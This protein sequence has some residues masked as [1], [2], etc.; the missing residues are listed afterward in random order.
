MGPKAKR[1]YA[2]DLRPR[3]KKATKSEKKYM[4]DEFSTTCQYN[5]KYAIRL[6]NALR[7]MPRG[8][9]HRGR[10]KQ[11]TGP[12]ILEVLRFI[13]VKTNLPCSK[14]LKA[15]LSLWLP[16]YP[17]EIP[18][19][20]FD[21]LLKISPATIDRLMKPERA[22]YQKKGLTFTK[23]G[24]LIKKHIP[25]KT[26][27]WDETRPGF[28]EVDSVAHCGTSGAGSF[29]FT[30]NCVDIATTWTEQRA[31]WGKGER[32]VLN[33]MKNIEQSLPFEL[34]GFDCDNGSE[35][36]NWHLVKHYLKRK[37]PI[38]F[39]RAR[40]YHKNDNAHIEEKNW[41]HIRQYL[42]YQRFDK[43][44]LVD[45][46]NDLYT[47]EWRLYF[48]FFMPSVKLVAKYREGSKIIKKYDPP[49]TPLQRVLDSDQVGDEKKTQLTDL[50][51]TLNPFDLQ[52]QMSA[53]IKT[54]LKKVNE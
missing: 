21:A 19:E 17:Y 39:T 27:Q 37:K 5:R 18:E 41:T 33:A 3:Y 44:E 46:L 28:L 48:N 9:F 32:G 16:Y 7:K 29:A 11:Y 54:I 24:T 50:F 13:W 31:V 12:E 49:Q 26:N 20:V 30:I 35:F 8:T 47:K 52:E 14:R 25:I 23:P 2:D 42:G 43:M 51:N 53:K 6:L 4:L 10:K 45:M 34:L 15:I 40:A 1:E 38:Q 22:K 36:L